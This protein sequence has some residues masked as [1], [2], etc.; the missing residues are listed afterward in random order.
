MKFGRVI[1]QNLYEKEDKEI[2]KC[3]INIMVI[4][5]GLELMVYS[6]GINAAP[7]IKKIQT[8]L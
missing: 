5:I 8:N 1:L 4:K 2:D 3:Y 6:K 7:I